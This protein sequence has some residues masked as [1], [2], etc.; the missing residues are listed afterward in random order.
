MSSNRFPVV[1]A[2]AVLA[3]AAAPA[4]CAAP[5]RPAPPDGVRLLG[6]RTLPWATTFQGTAVGGLSGLDHDPRT[7]QWVFVSDDRS[8]Q[9]PARFYTADVEIRPDGLGAWTLTGT[10]PFRRPDGATYP[11]ISAGDG[12]TVDPEEIR[13]DPWSHDVWWTSEGERDPQRIDPS[14]RSAA[15]DGSFRAE[16]PL[17][18]NLAHRPDSGPRRN[19]S[20]ESLAFAAGGSLVVDAVE[21][22]LLQDGDPP[23]TGH[24]A[25]SR[26]TVQDRGG[27]VLSQHAYPVDPV[28]AESDGEPGDNGIAS[29]LAAG[30]DRY[31][32]LERAYVEGVGNSVRIYEADL[33]GSDDVQDVPSLRDAP[34][35]PVHKRLLADLSS[36]ELGTV[37]N[38][39][40]LTWGPRLPTGERTL[41]LVSDNNFSPTQTTQLIV[42]ALK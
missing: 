21:S 19:E 37:D 9:D 29:L 1:L 8:E 41:A 27:R 10:H 33:R 15:P 25:L 13:F 36:F 40:G 16:L 17:P 30:D 28:F 2:A 5:A 24:G 3:M 38:V 20:L 23:T 22:A 12:T 14:I 34:V 6:E 26:I 31:L 11:P 42:L 7:G 18:P 32:V 4:A 35:R 39:E